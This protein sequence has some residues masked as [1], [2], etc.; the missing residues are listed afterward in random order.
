[1]RQALQT[2]KATLIPEG[3]RQFKIK[4]MAFITIGFIKEYD[5]A[6]EIK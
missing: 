3:F 5:F 6:D 4:K 2:K 1:M